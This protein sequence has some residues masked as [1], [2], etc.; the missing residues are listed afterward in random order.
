MSKHSLM[1]ALYKFGKRGGGN[2]YSHYFGVYP[3]YDRC[4]RSSRNKGDV[5][6]EAYSTA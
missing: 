6:V 3:E 4:L 5:I 2:G 1:P